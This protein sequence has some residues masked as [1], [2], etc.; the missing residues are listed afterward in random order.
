MAACCDL[1]DVIRQ[2]AEPTDITVIRRPAGSFGADGY[3]NGGTPAPTTMTAH[4]Q[5][6]APGEAVR[7]L[8]DLQITQEVIAVYTTAVL[9]P[10]TQ[11][12][13]QADVITYEGE[14]YEVKKVRDFSTQGG[15]YK[16]LCERIP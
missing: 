5:P 6:V 14:D 4:V 12:D 3:Y 13:R 1:G 7:L 11:G 16:A 10:D 15:Y 2:F 8:P 9:Y